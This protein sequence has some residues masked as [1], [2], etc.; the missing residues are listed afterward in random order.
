[1]AMPGSGVTAYANAD[2]VA[3]LLAVTLIF[4]CLPLMRLV[5]WVSSKAILGREN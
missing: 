2:V 3:V 1:M 4:R 5:R